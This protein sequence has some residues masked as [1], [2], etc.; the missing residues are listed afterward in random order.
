MDVGAAVVADE[1]SASLVEPGEGALHDPAVAPEAGAVFGLAPRDLG[2]DAALPELLAVVLGVI[3]AVGKES[4]G[5]ATRPTDTSTH[6]RD[7]I[8]EGEQLGDV[9]AV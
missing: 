4:V 3:A 7:Q 8:D 2:F 6:R 1:Q 5:P 9:M